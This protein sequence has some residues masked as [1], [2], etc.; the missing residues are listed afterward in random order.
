MDDGGASLL[1]SGSGVSL[2]SG[3]A[4]EG[5]G[6]LLGVADDGGGGGGALEGSSTVTA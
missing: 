4:L 5:I 3:V 2:G 6:V 1:G